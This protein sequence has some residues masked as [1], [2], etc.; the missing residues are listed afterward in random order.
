MNATARQAAAHQLA[1]KLKFLLAV[2]AAAAF[3]VAWTLVSGNQVGAATPATQNPS[4]G[5]QGATPAQ[6]AT[7]DGGFFG[8][9][10]SNQGG[11]SAGTGGPVFRTRRS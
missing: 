1:G 2:G 6:P 5:T 11:V 3:G 7:S 10:P 8:G 9:Q 4:D